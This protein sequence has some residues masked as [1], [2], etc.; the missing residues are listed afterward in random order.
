V[1]PG[2]VGPEADTIFG[3]LFEKEYKITN[4]ES[5]TQVNIS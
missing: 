2:F 5:G 4:T 1:D 3:A